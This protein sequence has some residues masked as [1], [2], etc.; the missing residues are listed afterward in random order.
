MAKIK[1]LQYL[2]YIA[3]G[4]FILQDIATDAYKGFKEG[5]EDGAYAAG[6]DNRQRGPLLITVLNGDMLT[7]KPQGELKIDNDY[8]LQNISINTEVRLSAQAGTTPWWLETIFGIVTL[9]A[10]AILILVAITINKIIV[11]IAAGSMFDELCIK[12]IR[13]TA[14]LLLLFTL[15]DY[16]YQR[17]AYFKNS[18]LIH[19]P[20][21]SVANTSAFNFQVLLCAI[22]IYIIAEAFKQGYR[23]KQEQD[24]T[25]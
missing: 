16:L 23:L 25:I 3:F 14:R 17:L 6:H 2:V 18:R 13:Q 24:L 19:G 7:H 22:L 9:S 1:A 8:T 21:L 20:F 12:L 10:A 5:Y 15:F 4:L 11:K